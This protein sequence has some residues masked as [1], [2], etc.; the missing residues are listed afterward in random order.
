MRVLVVGSSGFVGSNLN[1]EI[2]NTQFYGLDISEQRHASHQSYTH[3]ERLDFLT[4]EAVA[5][6]KCLAPDS[7]VLLAGVQFTSPIQKKS[8]RE[9]A[10]AKNVE[11]ARQAYKVMT[12]TPTV[13]KIIFV[14]TDMVYGIQSE[15]FVDEN[16]APDPIGEYGRSK[17]EAENILL[18]LNPR[19]VIFRP[20]LI[21]G[22][23]R[24][25]TIKLISRFVSANLP[26]P[27]IG[28]GENKYQM[29]SVYDLWSAIGKCFDGKIHGIYNL[30]SDNP[31]TLNELF[32]KVI[33]NLARSNRIMRFPRRITEQLLLL[34]DSF[35]LS[36]LAPEQFLI[37]G[38]NCVLNTAKFKTATGWEP[39]YADEEIITQALR[40]LI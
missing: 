1:L 25:G 18:K 8:D 24:V 19:I 20:R 39:Q 31:P 22:P 35:N 33:K 30:G 36:P 5:Y 28:K 23:G 14:S 9:A 26:I 13:K 6:V 17:L 3:F 34:L 38:Q 2:P 10:F 7:I 40:N 11:I 16:C 32:P 29:I 37:A 4:E 21:V 12:A 15:S 27:F